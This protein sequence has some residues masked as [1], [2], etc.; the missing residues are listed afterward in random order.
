[1]VNGVIPKSYNEA[2]E[3]IQD[4]DFTIIAGGTDLMVKRRSWSGLLP[5]FIQDVLFINSIEELKNIRNEEGY[6]HIGANVTLED[7][8][9]YKYTPKV[10]KEALTLMA[11]PAIRHIGTIG[12]NIG[13]AS[14]A[15]DTLPVL[16]ILDAEVVIASSKGER[17]LPIDDFILGPGKTALTSKELIK[18]IVIKEQEFDYSLYKKIGG[19]KADA[20]SKVSFVG[21]ANIKNNTIEDFRMAFGAVGPTV[22]RKC[23]LEQQIIGLSVDKSKEKLEWL[24]EQY[25]GYI[26]PIDDQ[27]STARYRKSCSINLLQYFMDR[28]H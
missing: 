14:P 7:L 10:F 15:G 18:E 19:R 3:L 20:I 5:S 6:I 25:A 9:H 2:L 28:I 12:G 11:S 4:K 22:V 21:V 27:R 17:R 13:N 26:I 16:Y 23:E 1:M 8:M 24:K